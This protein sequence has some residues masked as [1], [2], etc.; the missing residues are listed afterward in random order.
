MI[1]CAKCMYSVESRRSVTIHFYF[2]AHQKKLHKY[3]NNSYF[4]LTLWPLSCPYINP[5]DKKESFII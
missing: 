1:G 2:T 3:I 4:T 5:G